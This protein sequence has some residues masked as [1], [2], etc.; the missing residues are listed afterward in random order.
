MKCRAKHRTRVSKKKGSS[1][2]HPGIRGHSW[3]R[4]TK[5]D[6]HIGRQ[7][8]RCKKTILNPRSQIA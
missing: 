8:T 1:N 3:E 6:T 4:L 5:N 7:C 2:N